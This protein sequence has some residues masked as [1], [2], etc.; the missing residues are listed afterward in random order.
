MQN[1]EASQ[2][3]VELKEQNDAQDAYN[4]RGGSYYIILQHTIA[5]LRVK[6]NTADYFQTRSFALRGMRVQYTQLATYIPE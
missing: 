6:Y 2:Q 3:K 4:I 5:T 1:S